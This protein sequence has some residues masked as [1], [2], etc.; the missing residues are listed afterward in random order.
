MTE[1]T[2]SIPVEGSDSV[3]VTL[4]YTRHGPVTHIDSLN[5][6]AYAVKGAWMEIGGAPYLASLRMDQAKNWEEF[7]KACSYSHIPGENMR[8][9]D[10]HGDIGWQ[11]AGIG[12]VLENFSGL[13]PIPG[14]GRYEWSGYLPIRE[15]PHVLNPKEGYVVTANEH[16]TPDD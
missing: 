15:R 12:P 16:V 9:A 1:L 8:W 4:R 2:E 10:K 7:R 6:K 11:V 3:E 13:I 5:L 14:D